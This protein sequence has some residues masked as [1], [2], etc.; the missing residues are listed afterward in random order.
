MGTTQPVNGDWGP[1]IRNAAAKMKVNI[2]DNDVNRIKA[3]IDNESGGN[4]TVTQQVW[5]QNMAAGTPAQGLLQYV[6]ST[7]NAYAVDGHRNIKSGF[8][9]LLAFFNNSTWSSDISLHGWG[10]NGSKRFDK[11]PA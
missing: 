1:V 5:D 9:Q 8:D 7:F 2:S 11:I 4:Q 10:P 3:L 6:P